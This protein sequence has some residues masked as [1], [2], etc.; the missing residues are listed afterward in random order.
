MRGSSTTRCGR[1]GV[2]LM[3][4]PD[5]AS[6]VARRTQ[7]PGSQWL[8][9]HGISHGCR[10]AGRAPRAGRKPDRLGTFGSRLLHVRGNGGRCAEHDDEVDGTRD[11]RK[12]WHTSPGQRH[13]P[14]R[15]HRNDVV[16]FMREIARDRM[17][18][19]FGTRAGADDRD[20]SGPLQ[21]VSH[22]ALG[23]G[24]VFHG[25]SHAL[26]PAEKRSTPRRWSRTWQVRRSA[27]GV[28]GL[29]A[30][31]TPPRRLAQHGGRRWL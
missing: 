28:P 14:I 19:T 29:G 16:T 6:Q 2:Q 21:H 9:E 20:R 26:H 5:S 24:Q 27:R 31:A 23:R 17:T 25:M 18:V 30:R 13:Q 12:S 8:A 22:D 15:A 4:Q 10:G 7:R 11:I 1:G 3:L